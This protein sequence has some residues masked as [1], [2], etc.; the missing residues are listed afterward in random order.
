[1]RKSY[2]WIAPLVAVVTLL[3]LGACA[4]ALQSTAPAI[5]LITA[6][7][8]AGAATPT[9][10]PTV[11]PTPTPT[12][13]PTGSNVKI[14]IN[15]VN[16]RLTS[17]A[18]TP[19]AGQGQVIYYM[20]VIPPV[21]GNAPAVTGNGTFAASTDTSYTWSNVKPGL[22]VFS[23]ELVK[24]DRS[25]LDS[26]VAAAIALVVG[27]T[28][29]V[30]ATPT[31]TATPSGQ[32]VTISLTVQNIAFDKS[33][34]SVPAGAQVT[35]NFMNMDSGIPH[36]FAVYT[37]SSASTPIFVGQI[38][39]GPSSISYKFTAPSQPGNYF[40]RCD[41][42]PTLMTGTFTVTGP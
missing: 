15:I 26:P 6:E 8:L 42:H 3:S 14:S 1:M 25:P 16:F 17:A 4:P 37:N 23:V 11:S 19:A 22:H 9:P 36:N 7:V 13:A 18:G 41:V 21:M 5:T 38:I 2:R 35:V 28:S 39:T 27:S 29:A 30:S 31:P 20:D 33:T 40:F 34:I 10:T 24:S 32:A 12:T